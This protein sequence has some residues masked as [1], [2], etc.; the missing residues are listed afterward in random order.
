MPASETI[1]QAGEPSTALRGLT[2]PILWIILLIWLAAI[3]VLAS[4]GAFVAPEDLPPAMLLI[5]AIAPAIL[6]R[7]VYGISSALREWVR[8][9][10]LALIT[11]AQTWRVIGVAFLLLWGLGSLPPYFAAFAGFGDLAVGFAAALVTLNVARRTG[12][13]RQQS[14]WLIGT[15]M[16]DFV[17]AF[18]TAILS[19]TDRILAVAGAPTAGLMQTLPMV[20]IPA[21]AVPLF[22]IL[23][24]IAWLKLRGEG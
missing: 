14:Y 11:A 15:G 2:S 24:L 8:S 5:A 9:L 17:L 4:R 13:W 21:Y 6:F 7:L 1:S 19:D 16:L 20:L 22:I 18:G 12:P 3:A 23:H 10:D